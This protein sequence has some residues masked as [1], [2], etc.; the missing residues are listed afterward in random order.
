MGVFDGARRGRIQVG[1][2]VRTPGVTTRQVAS[3]ES[4]RVGAEGGSVSAQ[5][6]EEDDD[7]LR[8]FIFGVTPMNASYRIGHSP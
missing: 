6:F 3:G 2:S 5:V 7:G 8:P 1:S 4:L